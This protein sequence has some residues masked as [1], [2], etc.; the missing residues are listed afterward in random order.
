[1]HPR[2]QPPPPPTATYTAWP[3][4]KSP[5]G[6]ELTPLS[7]TAALSPSSSPTHAYL[8]TTQ[9]ESFP[10]G[11]GEAVIFGERGQAV[12]KLSLA[13]SCTTPAPPLSTPD[14]R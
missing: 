13:S 4:S 6:P 3:A 11:G 12:G 14:P 10:G 8:S 2:V 1:M 5:G 7:S 9:L